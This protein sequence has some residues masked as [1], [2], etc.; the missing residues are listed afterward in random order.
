MSNKS[1]VHKYPL[2]LLSS[3]IYYALYKPSE[4]VDLVQQLFQ[5]DNLSFSFLRVIG[6]N[7]SYTEYVPSHSFSNHHKFYLTLLLG[8]VYQQNSSNGL[9][10]HAPYVS[11]Y[12]HMFQVY[13]LVSIDTFT[14]MLK[15]FHE[16]LLSKCQGIEGIADTSACVF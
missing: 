16:I 14:L 10:I 6:A 15:T 3:L 1:A 5:Y 9:V 7:R 8:K 2:R 12:M 13:S 4:L 11:S